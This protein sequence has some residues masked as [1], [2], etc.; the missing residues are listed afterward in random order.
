VSRL[1]DKRLRHGNEPVCG[2]SHHGALYH[3][4]RLPHGHSHAGDLPGLHA[5]LVREVLLLARGA[6]CV[7]SAITLSYLYCGVT[8][9]AFT[10][11]L[12]S[13]S[14]FSI[15]SFDGLADVFLQCLAEALN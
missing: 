15:F 12:L 13:F 7:W 3:N 1:L 6:P 4:D 10:Q 14:L 11:R 9:Y 5:V 8:G 2:C